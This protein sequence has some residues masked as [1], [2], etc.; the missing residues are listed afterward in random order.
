MVLYFLNP[1][2]SQTARQLESNVVA[3]HIARPAKHGAGQAYQAL[4]SHMEGYHYDN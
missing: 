1:S 4:N 2:K 3:S